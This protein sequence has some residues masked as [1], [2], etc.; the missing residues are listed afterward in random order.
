MMALVGQRIKV[1]DP[2]ATSPSYPPGELP[3]GVDYYAA[4]KARR[5]VGR[6]GWR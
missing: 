5:R 2:T 3:E 4:E 1:G 6:R